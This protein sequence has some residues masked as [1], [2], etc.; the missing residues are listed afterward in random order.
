ML[1]QQTEIFL[2]EAGPASVVTGESGIEG[3]D[4]WCN[5]FSRWMAGEG[6]YHVNQ[7]GVFQDGE[8]VHDRLAADLA[9]ACESRGFKEPAALGKEEFGKTFERVPTFQAKEGLDI[10]GP[11]RIHPLLKGRLWNRWR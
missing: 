3:I 4:F 11:V 9:G 2:T 1:P 8:I 5:D 6:P 7:I 10:F